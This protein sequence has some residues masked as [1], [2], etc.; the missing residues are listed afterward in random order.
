MTVNS[1][2]LD[3]LARALYKFYLHGGTRGRTTSE[4]LKWLL[5]KYPTTT[6]TAVGEAVTALGDRLQLAS[7]GRRKA[8]RMTWRL[9]CVVSA[10]VEDISGIYP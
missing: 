5:E 9:S 10:A 2:A 8:A 1:A 7:S 3:D 4:Q 6:F